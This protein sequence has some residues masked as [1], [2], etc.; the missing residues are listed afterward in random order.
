[1]TLN[2]TLTIFFTILQSGKNV[3]I[4]SMFEIMNIK[5]NESQIRYKK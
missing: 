2:D 4:I 3:Y 1:M 5:K